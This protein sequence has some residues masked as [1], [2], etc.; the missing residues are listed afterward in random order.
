MT[1]ASTRPQAST[2]LLGP[3]EP[4]PVEV[5]NPGAGSPWLLTCDHAGRRLPRAL[6]DLGLPESELC[7]HIAWDIGIAP[8]SRQLAAALD[9]VM[10]AQPYSRLVID[11]NRPPEVESSI[12]LVSES[13]SIPGN[14]DLSGADR[15]AR[16][17]EVFRPYHDRI[18]AE[19]DCRDAH[20]TR[21]VLI[22]MHSFTAVYRGVE[23]PWHVGTLYGRDGRLARALRQTLLG[24]DG[25]VVGDNE[26]YSVSD[27]T[28]YTIPVHG[29]ARGL[30]HVG[31]E[32]RQDL[33]ASPE[34]QRAWAER[35]AK[36]LPRALAALDGA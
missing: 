10:I 16:V 27:E 6:G 35:L 26:P 32:M 28:D 14:L 34:G 2:R 3:D 25:L 12:P 17:T 33:V 8:V 1:D 5:V 31:I 20:G 22:A 24:E 13:T 21:T 4:E 15:L 36:C 19:L 18:A 7:R 11:C 23:R 30:V 29:E 9:A